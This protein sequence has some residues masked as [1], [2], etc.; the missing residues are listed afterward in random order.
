MQTLGLNEEPTE[1]RVDPSGPYVGFWKR[2]F[3]QDA[4]DDQ[5]TFDW[6]FGIILPVACFFLDPIVFESH[7]GGSAFLGDYK[8]FAYLL[9]FASIMALM[10]WLLWGEKL[11]WLNA[12]LAGIF[13]VGGIVSLAVGLVLLP[14]SLLGLF[15]LI[16]IL[17][18]TPLLTSLVF[19]R[20]S[21][22]ALRSARPYLAKRSLVYSS[23]L[24]A[25]FAFVVPYVANVEIS[26][27]I[28]AMVEADLTEFQ[29][30]ARVLRF[31]APLLNLDRLRRESPDALPNAPSNA[32]DE[33]IRQFYREIKGRH[34]NE[35]VFSND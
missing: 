22:R 34:A 31:V 20:N 21:V 3:Q 6:F 10:A 32:K 11:R 14:L 23:L 12:P 16:G 9:S 26:R 7:L 4:T 13:A 19:A 29:A 35:Y 24:T 28:D 33:A 1:T 15:F 8:P 2:Q 27:R 30:N 5:K 25:L 17:G 18:F